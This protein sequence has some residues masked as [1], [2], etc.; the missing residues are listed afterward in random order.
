[1]DQVSQVH[2]VIESDASG[3]SITDVSSIGE[4][5]SRLVHVNLES[6]PPN[7]LA[8]DTPEL[9][10]VVDEY[11][12]GD[13]CEETNQPRKTRVKFQCCSERMM[14]RRKGVLKKN[15][16]PF[17]SDD[18]A[19][20]NIVEDRDQVCTYEITVCTTFLCDEEA[21]PIVAD[22]PVASTQRGPA[23]T[24]EPK[25]NDSIRNILERTLGSTCLQSFNGGWWSYELCSFQD[26]RQYHETAIATKTKTGGIV[27]SKKIETEHILGLYKIDIFA[28]V[29]EDE[30]WKLVVNA[31]VGDGTYFEV[32]YTEGDVCDHSDVTA[33]AIVAGAA[34]AG[35]VARSSSIRYYCGEKYELSV[36]EDST[37]H[38]I[39]DVKVPALCK[40]P[41]F[42]LPVAKKQLIKCLPAEAL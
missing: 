7:V 9:A 26:V 17:K 42:K 20:M 8:E 19:V 6:L 13:I 12:N 23:A 25:K 18:I 39:V 36:K 28:S 37:C 5:T 14:L 41:L 21:E 15:G 35:G 11:A 32:E 24:E 33:S 3:I 29:P 2:I 38:Y 31:T 4:Y 30:E 10:R 16:K 22:V 27:T 1:M 40:H 34:S